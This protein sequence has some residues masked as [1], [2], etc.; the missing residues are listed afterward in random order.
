MLYAATAADF[1]L[2]GSTW[3][4]VNVIDGDVLVKYTY[5]GD[6]NLDGQVTAD[7]Y[8]VIDAFL[9]A[10][11]P[12]TNIGDVNKDGLVNADDYPIVDAFLGSGV[13]NPLAHSPSAVPE[14]ASISLLVL[15]ASLLLKRRR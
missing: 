14:P 6:A 1:G 4:G 8:A 11:G 15:G 3:D 9:G 12:G 10:S 13:G 5:Y 7:D 2:G